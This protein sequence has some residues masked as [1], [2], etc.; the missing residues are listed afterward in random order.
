MKVAYYSLGCKVNLYESQTVINQFLD[1]G[2]ELVNFNDV[3]DV[4]IINTCSI[5]HVSDA[6]SRKIIREAIKRNSNAI[7]AV[8]GCYSQLKPEDIKAIDGVDVLV[9]T[10][11][12][13]KLFELVM[14]KINSKTNVVD[15]SSYTEVLKE[16][17]YEELKLD[18]YNNK[19]RGFVKVQEGCDNY[20]SYCTVPFAR[21]HIRSR[22]IENCVE[23]ITKL[24]DLGMKEII[25]SGLNTGAYGKDFNKTLSDLLK[26]IFKIPSLGR[27]RIS[28]IEE[29]EN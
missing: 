20:C 19:T 27:I 8:M 15:D 28:S 14:S 1:A 9:G 29:T 26:E 6:K 21:G 17:E 2:F 24:S 4:Y 13:S 16:K 18:R 25:L 5:T 3:S 7:V 10:T 12:R 11:N 22:K 23:E